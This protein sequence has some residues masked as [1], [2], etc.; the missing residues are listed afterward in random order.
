VLSGSDDFKLY[1]WKIPEKIYDSNE[2][3]SDST[4]W[5]EN[6]E[7]VLSGHRY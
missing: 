6:A 4:I 1:M 3:N 2:L 7:L 5:V